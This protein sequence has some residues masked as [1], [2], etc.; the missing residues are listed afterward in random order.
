[1]REIKTIRLG[2][3]PWRRYSRRVGA[4]PAFAKAIARSEFGRFYTD[5]QEQREIARS[6]ARAKGRRMSKPSSQEA[7]S[8]AKLPANGPVGKSKVALW[9]EPR[10]RERRSE[11]AAAKM[12]L[13][14][15]AK[16][17]AEHVFKSASAEEDEEMG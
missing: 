3:W 7:A 16:L 14:E 6:L 10:V 13:L 17:R 4:D 5:D 9:R 11:L 2:H 15:A 8:E 1:M 12:R